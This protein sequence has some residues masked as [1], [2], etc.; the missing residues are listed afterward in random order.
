MPA[1]SFYLKKE[2]LDAVRARASAGNIPV[3]RIIS[4]RRRE[5]PENR[6]NGSGPGSGSW[7]T[8]ARRSRPPA[9][10][11]CTGNGAPPMLTGIDTSFF[12]ALAAG[13]PLR[14][15]GLG[16]PGAAHLR[17]LLLRTAKKGCCIGDLK[18]WPT[19]LEDI[20]KAVEVVPVTASRRPAGRP[21]R[22]RDGHARLRRDHRQ[23]VRRGRLRGDP[24]PGPHF[25]LVR[26]KRAD[27]NPFIN[28]R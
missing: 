20:A 24:H 7:T 1:V 26:K 11:R 15:R 16:E 23:L 22:P 8:S 5:F 18:A 9:G 28:L 19:V 21:A 14:G 10:K 6:R 4:L 12:Y 2:V 25:T 27:D 3:S 13:R 17:A